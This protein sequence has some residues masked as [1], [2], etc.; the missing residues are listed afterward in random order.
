M[1]RA[2]INT[3]KKQSSKMLFLTL[4]EQFVTLQ[5]IAVVDDVNV[6]LGM[7][8]FAAALAKESIVDVTGVLV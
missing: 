6:S 5:A 1:I 8:G 2:R 3:K 7:V 4:R